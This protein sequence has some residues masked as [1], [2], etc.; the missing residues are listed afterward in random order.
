M[1][2]FSPTA[3]AA[4]LLLFASYLG[5]KTEKVAEEV[6]VFNCSG[7]STE[8]F[9]S[10][11]GVLAG[12]AIKVD[13]VYVLKKQPVNKAPNRWK[14]SL[15]GSA[16]YESFS[17]EADKTIDNHKGDHELVVTDEVI[18]FEGSYRAGT[19]Q[20]IPTYG[21]D[22]HKLLIN[23]ATG[24]WAEDLY[25]NVNWSEG[26]RIRVRSSKVGFCKETKKQPDGR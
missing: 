26:T 16:E 6:L 5:A 21:D 1:A 18:T 9:E 12:K 3:F 11:S 25:N 2:R 10:R 13:T 19:M 22:A 15:N 8:V 4:S 7:K 17:A 20:N 14:I 24:G 23:R